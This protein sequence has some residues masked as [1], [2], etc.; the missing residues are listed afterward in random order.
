[1]SNYELFK[2]EALQRFL[3]YDQEAVIRR[4]NLQ[5]DDDYIYVDFCTRHY[6][7]GRKTPVLEK[8]AY[9]KETSEGA[10]D[11]Q[12]IWEATTSNEALSICDLLCHT[13]API[14]ISGEYCTIQRLNRVQGGNAQVTL[15]NGFWDHALSVFDEKKELLAK[16]CEALGGIPAGKGDVA[17]EIPLFEPIR[18]RFSFYESDDEF[19]AE[20]T[21]L[22]AAEIC[23]FLHYE[24]LYYIVNMLIDY[25]L[26]Y[27]NG[28]E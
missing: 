23:E 20:M 9:S 10:A 12:T 1:M 5:A 15:G 17:Y 19:D 16:A 11:C 28:G 6:R 2:Q 22:F 27:M 26:E 25:L 14:R 13:E 7:L 24:T 3:T 8:I 18:M 4:L 21:F